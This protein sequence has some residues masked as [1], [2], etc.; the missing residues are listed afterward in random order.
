G[1]VQSDPK[2]H[3]GEPSKDVEVLGIVFRPDVH[4]AKV[5]TQMPEPKVL[6]ATEQIESSISMIK[7]KPTTIKNMQKL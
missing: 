4:N 1:L 5:T 2:D 6:E 7:K 3:V